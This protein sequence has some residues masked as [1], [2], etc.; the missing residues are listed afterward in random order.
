[1]T[2]FLTPLQLL[3]AATVVAIIFVGAAV[4]VYPMVAL[5]V[6][7]LVL[8]ALIASLGQRLPHLFLLCLGVALTGY[9]FFGRGF[10]YFGFSIVFVGEIL[11]TLAILAS[12][13]V[14]HRMK[15]AFVHVLIILFMLWGLSRT[16]PYIDEYGVDA[17]RDAALWGYAFFAI[18]VSWL[19]RRE[20]IDGL[21]TWY[22]RLLPVFL[23]WSP[24]ALLI[25]V[26]YGNVFTVPG[27]HN[28]PFLTARPGEWA[29]HVAGGAAFILLGLWARYPARPLWSEVFLWVAWLGAAALTM[30]MNRA[31]MLAI[32]IG[33]CLAVILRPARHLATAIFAGL[34]VIF[35]VLFIDPVVELEGYHRDFTVD[36]FVQNVRSVVSDSGTES[37]DQTRSWR[38]RWWEQIVDETLFGPYRWTGKGFGRNLAVDIGYIP[39]GASGWGDDTVPRLRSPHNGHLTILARMGLPGLTIWVL[40]QATFFTSLVATAI[41]AWKDGALYWFQVCSWLIVYWFVLMINIGFEVYLEGPQGG[42]WFWTIIGLGIAVQ[43]IYHDT[44]SPEPQ[45]HD[46]SIGPDHS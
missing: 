26:M 11:L 22:G 38:V 42:I 17:F 7:G 40:L 31:S 10:A 1:M 30:A 4:A 41:R 29:V 44:Q 2:C 32:A 14:I 16:V 25:P 43:R 20:H 24:I 18:V 9:A 34:I 23:V 45:T 5:L 13:V 6:G 28:V 37:L 3:V 33:S 8:V 46:R 21:I 35:M 39:I 19:V 15:F 36:Q 27:S 12:L